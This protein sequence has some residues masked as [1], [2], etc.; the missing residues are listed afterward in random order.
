MP[1]LVRLFVCASFA[2]NRRRIPELLRIRLESATQ[3][4]KDRPY[5]L[6]ESVVLQAAEAAA[7]HLQVDVSKILGERQVSDAQAGNADP[8][9]PERTARALAFVRL[10]STLMTL[11]GD[12][13]VA[14]HWLQQPNAALAGRPDELIQTHGGLNSVLEYL[15]QHGARF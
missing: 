10:Y 7:M 13:E 5:T 15:I 2:A 1:P 9:M 3:P 4:M 8:D 6:D 12:D 11:V 14:R